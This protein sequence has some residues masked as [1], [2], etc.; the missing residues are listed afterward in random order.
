MKIFLSIR[1]VNLILTNQRGKQKKHTQNS[2]NII[3]G[4]LHALSNSLIV[5]LYFR[6]AFF[7][8]T[9]VTKKPHLPFSIRTVNN[10]KTHPP[11]FNISFF[12]YISGTAWATNKSLASSC[13]LF[14][15]AF[16]CNKNFW[17]LVSKS[18]D[19]CKNVNLPMKS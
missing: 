18:A 3:Q 16:S 8:Y 19:I 5:N 13:I 15:R 4:L 2:G 1:P 14:W 6:Q 7:P 12:S 17:H 9:K 10:K 11:F